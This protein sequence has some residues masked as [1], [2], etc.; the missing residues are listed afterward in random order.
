VALVIQNSRKLIDPSELRLKILLIAFPG[1]GKT[2]FIANCPNVGIGVS[3]TGHG[4]GLISVAAKGIDYVEINSF[5]DFSAF[6]SGAVFKEKETIGCDSLSDMAKSFIK[7]KAL[8]IPR[9]KGESVKRTLGVPELDD[10]GVMAELTRK[11]TKKLIDQPKHIVVSAGLRVDR[12]DP[13]NLQA[14]TLVGPDF[15]GQMFLGSTAMFDIVLVGRTR[16]MLK[17]PKD[18]KSKY[19][20]RYWMT[21]G[22]GGYLAKNRLSVGNIGSF[23]PA[24]LIFDNDLG[25]GT[26]NDLLTRSKD[27]YTKFLSAIV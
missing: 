17:D 23:L 21:E 7:D 25:T 8:S 12:P 22:S 3:E 14:D 19:T 11:Y 4:K 18:P 15:P 2:T 6:A 24:E 10:Y 9:T 16:G 1:F 13:E 20:Q 26:F 5:D 27:A